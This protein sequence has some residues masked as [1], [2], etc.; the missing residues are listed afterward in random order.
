[1]CVDNINAN[2]LCYKNKDY[3]SDSDLLRKIII[4]EEG[5]KIA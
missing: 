2:I 4:K 5:K 1:M 3:L